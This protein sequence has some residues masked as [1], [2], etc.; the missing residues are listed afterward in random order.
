MNKRRKIIE[1][2][3]LIYLPLTVM[4]LFV[5]IPFVWALVTSFKTPEA[6]TGT[7]ISL[8]PHPAVFDNYIK[9]WKTNKFST[10]FINS[11]LVCTAALIVIV[12]CSV[13][14][15]YAL[16]RFNFKGKKLFMLLLIGTQLM[17]VIIL[18]IP[19]FVI[20]KQIGLINTRWSLIVFYIAMQIPFNSIL[21]KGFVSGIPV[22]IEEAAWVDGAGRVKTM[23]L[24]VFP[25][26]LPGIVATGAFAFVSCWNEF[27]ISF[28][29]ITSQDLFT[30][31]VALKYMIGEYTIDYGS[32]AAGSIIALIPP[33][34][35]F[36]Y[37]QKYLISGLGA[38]AVKG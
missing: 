6:I 27:M 38:G 1:K 11:L 32:L 15:G 4:M 26:L 2:I 10:Y 18:I 14:N 22:S 34:C 12:L 8:L 21:M 37:I 30:I 28:S 24:V 31:P 35:L 3:F 5:L 19:L 13:L 9:V 29:F 16:A 7:E 20:F 33:V 17:P 23:L 36:A 25:S